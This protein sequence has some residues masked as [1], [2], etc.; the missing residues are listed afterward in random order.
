M[1]AWQWLNQLEP[2]PHRHGVRSTRWKQSDCH[3]E[4]YRFE[5]PNSSMAILIVLLVDDFSY[6][7]SCMDRPC[8]ASWISWAG[9]DW[10][11]SSVSGPWWSVLCSW[12]SWISRRIRSYR[13]NF[14][15]GSRHL[16]GCGK[17]E[18]L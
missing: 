6:W 3:V 10:S 13:L 4:G 15:H 9:S 12:P 18:P 2:R 17:I 14:C 1:E 8:L 7:H 16:G 11:C 5:K